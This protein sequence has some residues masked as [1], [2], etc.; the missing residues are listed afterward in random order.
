[1]SKNIT[2]LT[3]EIFKDI[4]TKHP[5]LLVGYV[6]KICGLNLDPNETVCKPTEVKD[7]LRVRRAIFDVRYESKENDSFVH[8]DL[9]AQKYRPKE[10]EFRRREFF[11]TSKLYF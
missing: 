11:Y 5:N 6:N 9:E 7:N 8:I 1:M 2:G 10:T 3:D 4:F